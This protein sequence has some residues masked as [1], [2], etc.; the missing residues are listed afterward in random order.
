MPRTDETYV[1]YARGPQR[2]THHRDAA[3]RSELDALDKWYKGQKA[4]IDE[5]VRQKRFQDIRD[6]FTKNLKPKLQTKGYDWF[7]KAK[8]NNARLMNFRTYFKDLSDFERVYENL[9][10]DFKKL[11]D[12]CISLEKAEDPEK[13]LAQA[14]A[15]Q[16]NEK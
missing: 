12:F 4:P 10:K 7:A 3:L 9:G 5:D 6:S 11:I 15:I 14:A 13:A 16:A 1:S 8:L 2:L